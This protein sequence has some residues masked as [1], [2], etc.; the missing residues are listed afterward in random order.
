MLFVALVLIGFFVGGIPFG[1]IISKIYKKDPRKI[2]SGNIGATNVLR[3]VGIIPGVITLI[4]DF[5]KGLFMVL[6]AKFMIN[7]ISVDNFDFYYEWLPSAVA[8]ATILGHIFSPYLKFKGGKG[9]AT[10]LGTVVVLTP[11]FSLL[12]LFVFVLIVII[13]RYVSLGSIFSALVILITMT[14]IKYFKIDLIGDLSS[15][16]TY[17]LW[18]YIVIIT[19]FIIFA[20]RKNI[21]RL[22]KGEENKF[23]W[24]K[25]KLQ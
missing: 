7:H 18:F 3:T 20:H 1:L 24:K 8:L 16:I 9:V 13:F 5:L 2:G 15:Q 4:L 25:Q 10:S 22:F 11:L 14:V 19:F 6:V 17:G 23:S 12:G 21:K